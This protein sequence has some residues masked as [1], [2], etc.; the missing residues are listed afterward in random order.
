MTTAF[1]V[2][3]S[4]NLSFLIEFLLDETGSMDSCR[5]TTI[6][7]FNE[8]VNSQKNNEGECL[9]T[10]TKFDSHGLR[11]PYTDLNI[12]NVP[13][14]TRAGYEPNAMTN[15]YDAI[16]LR[17]KALEERAAAKSG[18]VSKLMV[19]M[20]DGK[21]NQ[22]REFTSD[23]IKKM[24]AAKEAE[25][26][27]FA[28]LGANQDAWQVGQ[29]FGMSK[30][31]TM[32]YDTN[33]VIGAMATLSAATTT[34]RSVRSSG[35]VGSMEAARGFFSPEAMAAPVDV[36]AGDFNAKVKLATDHL[37]KARGL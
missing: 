3:P 14:L 28:F 17:I 7:G 24:I 9:F 19:I 32:T 20:T 18:S 2:E 25:G 6:S 22:S 12:K 26:W 15:L 37:N 35:A 29:Q 16:G 13:V 11:T 30:G 34:Y 31:N 36:K 5:D 10:L 4:T 21:D 33:N 8:Y 1:K 27:S 23:S